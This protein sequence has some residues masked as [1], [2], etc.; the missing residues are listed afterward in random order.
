VPNVEGLPV[1]EAQSKLQAEKFTVRVIRVVSDQPADQVIASEPKA[2]TLRPLGSEVVLTVS[3]GP[4]SPPSSSGA[5][6]P[7]S[8]PNK[9]PVPIELPNLTARAAADAIEVLN[10]LGLKPK[11]VTVHSNAV[12]DGQVLSTTPAAA[13]KVDPGSDVTLT[14]ARNTAPV[15]LIAAAGKATWKSGSGKLT[16]PGSDGDTTGFVLI[17]DPGTLE[18]GTKVRVLETHPQW[19]DNG[20]IT[21]VYP[22]AEPVVPGDH[23]RARVG[24]LQNAS[25]GEVTFVVKANGK[26]IQQVNDGADGTLKDFDADLSPAKGATSIEI[27]VLAGTRSDQDWAVWQNLRLEPQVK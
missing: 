6:G 23:V 22:L 12:A 14:V 17:R 16:F 11:T 10:G 5:P 7:P 24:L 15:D 26:I 1:S 13:S 20:F 19:V 27:T 2:T 4:Q 25:D 21:G 3:S 9:P 8:S 18:D